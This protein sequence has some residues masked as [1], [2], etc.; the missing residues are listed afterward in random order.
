MEN[1]EDNEQ[2]SKSFMK[3]LIQSNFCENEINDEIRTLMVAVNY[4]P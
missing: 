3:E 2:K 4:E 1:D